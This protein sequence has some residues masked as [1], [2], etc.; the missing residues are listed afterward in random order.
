MS[1][2]SIPLAKT[3]NPDKLSYPVYLSVKLDGVPVRMDYH[4]DGSYEN[5]EV[6]VQTRQ[7]KPVRSIDNQVNKFKD[8]L[9]AGGLRGGHT[10]VA[11]VTHKS[12]TCSE[13]GTVKH[14]P[15]KDVSGLVRR[16]Q[17][18]DGLI[19]NIFD[20]VPQACPDMLWSARWSVLRSIQDSL[21][22]KNGWASRVH[23][24]AIY[25]QT[26]LEE[27]LESLF[28]ALWD[29]EGFIVR[30]HDAVWSPG[31]RRW[32]Y[33]KVVREPTVDL[34]IV[35]AEE[36]MSKDGQPLEMVGKLLAD[37]Q[38]EVIAIGPGKLSHA[39]RRKMYMELAFGSYVPRL[40]KIK[41]KKD[42]SY[43]KLRQPTFQCWRD[44]K[45]EVNAE[46]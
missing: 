20:Y 23:Q 17:Q 32:D 24:R 33:Q 11:E 37:F 8:D 45:S 28:Q 25:G 14:L 15:F 34:M 3:Y 44:D 18:C 41:Y 10:F 6:K 2:A 30:S 42:A 5:T 9:Y 22:T 29:A 16:D 43:S 26:D 12:T 39:E 36:A 21:D 27:S 38:G 4:S 40:A 31:S 46:I 7:G 19:L 1:D 13:T 35:D